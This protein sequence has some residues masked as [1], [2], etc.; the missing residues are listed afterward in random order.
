MQQQS[1]D[2][3]IEAIRS[4]GGSVAAEMFDLGDAEN[5]ARL[6]DVAESH[7]GGVDVLVID[8]TH[9]VLETF[10]PTSVHDQAPRISLTSAEGID[11][12]FAVNARA[13]ALMMR[14]YL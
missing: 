13:C 8:R 6:F 5:I 9:C 3:V 1:P 4:S 7:F 10:D 2:T 12:H 11:R 14:E